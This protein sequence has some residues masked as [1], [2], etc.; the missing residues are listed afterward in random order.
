MTVIKP[1]RSSTLQRK[2]DEIKDIF[3]EH[4]D[5][6]DSPYGMLDRLTRQQLSRYGPDGG[7]IE[8]T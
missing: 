5:E 6:N 7:S 4:G 8:E 1:R 2:T 3:G